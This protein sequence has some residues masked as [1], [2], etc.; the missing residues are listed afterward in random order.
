MIACFSRANKADAGVPPEGPPQ[1]AA[2]F[3]WIV[4][5][6]AAMAGLTGRS[7]LVDHL[8]AGRSIEPKLALRFRPLR[9]LRGP[10]RTDEG[11]RLIAVAAVVS[12]LTFVW[13]W[14]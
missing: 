2:P 11:P 14:R 5:A 1:L 7:I 9:P 12:L 8:D 3:I 10:A 6:S 13:V 4:P